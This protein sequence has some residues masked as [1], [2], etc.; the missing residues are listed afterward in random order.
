MIRD[1]AAK[2]YAEAAFEIAHDS[3]KLEEWRDGLSLIATVLSDPQVAAVLDSARVATRDKLRLVEDILA[4]LDPLILNLA[5]LLVAKGRHGIA[6]QVAEAYQELLD[7]HR[8]I[9]HALVTTA[10]A[11]SEEER[12]AVTRRLAEISGKQVVVETEVNPEIIGGLV[13]RIGDRLI[14]GSTRSKLLAL[15][16]ELQE[17]RG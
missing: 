13:A 16:R 1:I 7:A 17:A 15:R 11:L 3:D 6:A 10:V 14:D 2:R 8:G 4:G 9:A 12:Q 5:R